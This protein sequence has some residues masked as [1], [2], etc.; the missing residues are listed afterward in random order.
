MKAKYNGTCG[1]CNKGWYKG[2]TIGR[3][4]GSYVHEACRAQEVA[5]RVSE[6]RT[7]TLP[8]NVGAIERW[9]SRRQ[10]VSTRR[11][12]VIVR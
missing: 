11:N 12:A 9:R 7:T 5:R 2:A 8:G 4:E 3:W 1:M 10:T 6:G